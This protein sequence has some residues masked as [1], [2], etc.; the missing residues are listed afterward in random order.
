MPDDFE[1]V[2]V[3]VCTHP[4][5]AAVFNFELNHSVAHTLN[6][7]IYNG[8]NFTNGDGYSILAQPGNATFVNY[9]LHDLGLN[10]F[11]CPSFESSHCRLGMKFAVNVSFGA[12]LP[13]PPP[14]APPP[15]PPQDPPG[16]AAPPP[17]S[18]SGALGSASAG[19]LVGL[20]LL[21]LWGLV[22]TS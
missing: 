4:A 5:A 15:P 20:L 9:T 10:Y 12:G 11:G 22:A 16:V 2:C 19:N 3:C 17:P 1:L 13:P 21:L 18:P 8:C 6:A 7:T 14:A